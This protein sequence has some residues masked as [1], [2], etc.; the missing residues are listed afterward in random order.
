MSHSHLSVED[1]EIIALMSVYYTQAEIAER[2]NKSQSTVS[3]ELQRNRSP[4]GWYRPVAAHRRAHKRRREANGSRG[5]KMDHRDLSRNVFKGLSWC[6]SPEQISGRI[7]I[8]YDDMP[9]MWISHEM[10]Y[11]WIWQNKRQ[12]GSW[13]LKLRQGHKKHKRR[14]RGKADGRKTIPNRTWIDERPEEANDRSRFGDWEGDT[15]L[16]RGRKH[17]VASLTERRSQYLVLGKMN[18]RN[19]RTFNAVAQ[20]SFKRHDRVGQIPRQ[21]LTVDN[22]REFWGHED[23]AERLDV[24]VFFARTYQPWQRGLN[25]QVNGLIRQFMPKSTDLKTITVKELKRIENKLNNRPRKK[26]GYLTPLEVLRN[27]CHYAFRV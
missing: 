9:S 27:Q 26:L 4:D 23:L 25:E 22:G 1:R 19:W 17:A 15:I 16:G 12:G 3:R 2:I 13:H 11:T 18:E 21:T 10:I 14:A 24:D 7:R 8:E 20:R 5:R 6:W